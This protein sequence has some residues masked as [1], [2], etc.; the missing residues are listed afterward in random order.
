MQNDP[1]VGGEGCNLISGE[2]VAVEWHLDRKH[3]EL[4]VCG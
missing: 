4:Q 3:S 2:K 1:K